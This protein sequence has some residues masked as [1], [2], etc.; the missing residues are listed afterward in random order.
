MI[1]IAELIREVSSIKLTSDELATMVTAAEHAI[2]MNSVTIAT[3]VVGSRSGQDAVAS[4]NIAAKS[5]SDAAAS[6]RT[7]SKTCDDC[8][9]NLSK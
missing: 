8:I 6:V 9:A 7:L 3:L 5:L 4:V 2:A 1:S